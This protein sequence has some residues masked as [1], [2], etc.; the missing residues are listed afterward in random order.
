MKMILL[1]RDGTLIVDPP[2]ERIDSINK[3]KLMPDTLEAMK[4]LAENDYG[5]ILITN[6][7]GIA[8]GRL[9]EE[10]YWKLHRKILKLLKPS[11]VNILK[12]Y[13]CPHAPADRCVCR[14]PHPTMIQWAADDFDFSPSD[15]YMIGDR[16]TDVKAGIAANTKTILIKT[17]KNTYDDGGADYLAEDILDAVKYALSH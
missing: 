12:T 6:Q 14:K 10:E 15:V 5:V 8:E 2:D 17:L 11:G 16:V 9:T 7:A 3:V 1:D 13:L 4:Y